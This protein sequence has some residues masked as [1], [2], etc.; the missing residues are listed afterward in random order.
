MN[1][2]NGFS[3]EPSRQSLGLSAPLDVQDHSRLTSRDRSAEQI[4]GA[5]THEEYAGHRA[6]RLG[7]ASSRMK[8]SVRS[9]ASS[10]VNCCGGD[11]MK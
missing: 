3:F 2:C 7:R 4:V 9:R 8:Y 1:A 11:F 5:V 10:S 6:T